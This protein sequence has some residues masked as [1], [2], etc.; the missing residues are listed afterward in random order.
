MLLRFPAAAPLRKELAALVAEHSHMAA[1]QSLPAAAPL[2]ASAHGGGAKSGSAG[3]AAL[4]NWA[5]APLLQVFFHTAVPE[6]SRSLG[7]LYTRFAQQQA[8]CRADCHAVLGHTGV[9]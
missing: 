3:L 6:P 8:R 1:I 7:L 4:Q 2:L 9:L 5:P